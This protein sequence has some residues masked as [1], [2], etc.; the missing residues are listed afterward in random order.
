[1]N[2]QAPQRLITMADRA[3][4][5]IWLGFPLLIWM[6]IQSVV[7]SPEQLAAMAP[8]QAACLADIPQVVNFSRL[9]QAIFW[10][11]VAVQ[12]G[13]YAFLLA[14]AHRVIH[15]CATG[16]VFVMPMIGSLRLIGTII[17]LFPV[18]DLALTNLSMAAY[19][20]TGDMLVFIANYALDLPVMGMG[21]LMVVMAAAMRMAVQLHQ[22]AELTI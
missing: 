22:D 12:M 9:G 15:R 20:A 10:G 18:L 14:L 3:F 7:T 19:V 16:E 8:E 1:M 4:S 13:I 5:L 2:D 21:I 6:L 11:V 17:A